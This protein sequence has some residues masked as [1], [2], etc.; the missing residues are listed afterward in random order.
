[1]EISINN[2]RNF[3]VVNFVFIYLDRSDP[4]FDISWDFQLKVR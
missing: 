2:F 4:M 3:Y 1:M